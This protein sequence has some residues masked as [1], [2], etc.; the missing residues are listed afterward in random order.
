MA[1]GTLRFRR[2]YVALIFKAILDNDRPPGRR[3]NPDVPRKAGRYHYKKRWKK[4]ASCA[5]S[6]LR[7]CEATCSA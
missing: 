2:G 6:M 1:T 7:K 3:L 4:I 5:T